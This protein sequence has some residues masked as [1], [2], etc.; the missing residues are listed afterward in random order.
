M[1]Y[2][3]V[4]ER[5]EDEQVALGESSMQPVPLA[6]ASQLDLGTLSGGVRRPGIIP[7][8]VERWFKELTDRRLRRGVFSSVDDL[9]AAIEKW[10][11]HWNDDP[12][13]F[14]WHTP[15]A[16]IIEKVKRGRATLSQI[17]SATEH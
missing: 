6:L 8:H 10:V 1:S 5:L 9:I 15:A 2:L 17:K 7:N 16:E 13:P 3:G 12:T 4:V 14:V 11:K